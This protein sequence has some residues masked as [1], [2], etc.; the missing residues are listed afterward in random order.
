MV[1]LSK[2][3]TELIEIEENNWINNF[4]FSEF[5]N[6]FFPISKSKIVPFRTAIF[7]FNFGS[8]IFFYF[9][10]FFHNFCNIK[11]STNRTILWKFLLSKI[12]VL[13]I[14]AVWNVLKFLKNFLIW[15]DKNARFGQLL[16]IIFKC[17]EISK[18]KINR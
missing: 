5:W 3:F 13:E 14:L 2:Y 1:L 17:S 11:N 6:P 18:S 16:K 15:H 12:V 4:K 9:F 7:H 8:I 10:G